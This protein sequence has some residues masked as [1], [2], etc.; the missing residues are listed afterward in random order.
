MQHNLE[1]R[2]GITWDDLNLVPAAATLPTPL[3]VIHDES[4]EDVPPENGREIAGAAPQGTFVLTTGLGHRA[5]MRNAGVVGLAVD[6][7]SDRVP[8]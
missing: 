2:F 6:F 1:A 3:L 5:I 7:V 4:D 8:R